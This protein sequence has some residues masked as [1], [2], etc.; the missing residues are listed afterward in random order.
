MTSATMSEELL[1][2]HVV[3][4]LEAC[5]RP[6]IEWHHVPNGADRHPAVAKKMRL[7][8]VKRGVADLMLLID[9]HSYAVELKTEIGVLSRDQLDWRETFERAGGT[10]FAAFGLQEAI[11]VIKGIGAFRQ[12]TSITLSTADDGRGARRRPW[13]A[14]ADR[15]AKPAPIKSSPREVGA[16]A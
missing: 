2:Q 6:D 7:A 9:G 13:E 11:G 10:Y 16:P 1:Q 8:G 12:N 3:K 5:A 14:K 15:A 4:L